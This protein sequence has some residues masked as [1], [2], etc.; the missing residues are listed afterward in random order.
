[1][2]KSF[3][4]QIATIAALDGFT[5]MLIDIIKQ[6]EGTGKPQF[7]WDTPIKEALLNIKRISRI[8]QLNCKGTVHKKDYDEI[9]TAINESTKFFKVPGD[10]VFS[11]VSFISFALIGLDNVV[12]C[13]KGVKKKLRNNAKIN[14]FEEL[15]TAGFTL[16]KF[17]DPDLDNINAYEQADKARKYWEKIFAQ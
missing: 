9:Y 17:F 16:V 10:S 12:V 13:L 8:A 5:S 3:R 6:D 1:M 4:N 14:I 2:S 15:A 7:P 11:I